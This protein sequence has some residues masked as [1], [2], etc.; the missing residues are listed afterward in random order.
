[1]LCL[2]LACLAWPEFSEGLAA[3]NCWRRCRGLGRWLGLSGVPVLSETIALHTIFELVRATKARVHLCRLSSAAGVA[4]LLVTLAGPALGQDAP[5]T[6]PPLPTTE[7]MVTNLWLAADTVWVLIAGMLVFFMNLGFGC[8]ESGFA[9][10]K[11]CVNILSK[12]FI[13]FAAT[14]IAYFLFGWD[15]M[16]GAGDGDTDDSAGV[17]MTRGSEGLNRVLRNIEKHPA[18]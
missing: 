13:V 3:L 9:R 10:A 1:M 14:S 12:N 6:P 17:K 8:V 7:E 2:A 15:L 4:L 16:F 11:N 5:P 18:A